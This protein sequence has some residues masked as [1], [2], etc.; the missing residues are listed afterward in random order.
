[1]RGFIIL[2]TLF[3]SVG[4]PVNACTCFSPSVFRRL[5]YFSLRHPSFLHAYDFQ[6][7]ICASHPLTLS[8]AI[9][10]VFWYTSDDEAGTITGSAWA[11]PP[12]NTHSTELVI[13]DGLPLVLFPDVQEQVAAAIASRPERVFVAKNSDVSGF[14]RQV[15]AGFAM[16]LH[17]HQPSIPA[18]ANGEVINN[19]Q[20]MLEHPHE[21]VHV[22]DLNIERSL[23]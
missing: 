17:M 22:V 12:T 8:P 21:G 6:I 11:R 9:Y 10:L 19:L 1:M 16:A 5:S 20:Y 2:C 18:G 4:Q 14:A 3:A 15:R 13:K 23:F 7:S